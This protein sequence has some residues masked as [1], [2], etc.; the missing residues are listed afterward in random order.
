MLARDRLGVG[1][2]VGRVDER[3]VAILDADAD[4]RA[5]QLGSRQA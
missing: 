4:E 2:G 3:V 1:P 5:Q